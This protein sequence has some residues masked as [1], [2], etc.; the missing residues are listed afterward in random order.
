MVFSTQPGT[1]LVTMHTTPRACATLITLMTAFCRSAIDS[2]MAGSSGS[3]WLNQLGISSRQSISG[4]PS[5]CS[6]PSA[7]S[8]MSASVSL[9]R[10]RIHVVGQS[11]SSQSKK[12]TVRRQGKAPGRGRGMGCRIGL[13][14]D[15][16]RFFRSVCAFGPEAKSCTAGCWFSGRRWS[17]RLSEPLEEYFEQ[18][19][20]ARVSIVGGS[21][22]F[23][24][25]GRLEGSSTI[26]AG[27]CG[28]ALRPPSFRARPRRA[29]RPPTVIF[30]PLGE[31]CCGERAAWLLGV[32]LADAAPGAASWQAGRVPND[33]EQEYSE[34]GE[35]TSES[36]TRVPTLLATIRGGAAARGAGRKML[37]TG[38]ASN[39]GVDGL[40]I[41]GY[42]GAT[43]FL[44][45]HS[46]SWLSS[47]E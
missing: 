6:T 27:G 7:H 4:Q 41:D 45:L 47:A 12:K 5:P 13:S 17:S 23:E 25:T 30:W 20:C 21:K 18:S 42:S 24:R 39:C 1:A 11:V 10:L 43:C 14:S 32:P 36:A 15:W 3:G 28:A 33:A 26:G 44:L 19:N 38:A 37:L 29:P 9:R 22:D 46:E 16:Y 34:F 2:W 8:S 35:L 31:L 40:S